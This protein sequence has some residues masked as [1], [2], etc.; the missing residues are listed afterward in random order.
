MLPL[1]L[2]MLGLIYHCIKNRKD[3][4]VVFLMF[5]MTG[6]AIAI[7]LNMPP[8]QPRERD[9]AFVGSFYFFSVWIGLGVYALYDWLST[10]FEKKE[11]NGYLIAG[12]LCVLLGFLF[13]GAAFILT[14]IGVVLLIVSVVRL[15]K[16]VAMPLA[17][18][19]SMRL[20][21]S[22]SRFGAKYANSFRFC[23]F[24]RRLGLDARKF[25]TNV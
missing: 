24:F 4:F 17:F 10:K 9:Y 3:A 22:E 8:R 11:R 5:F 18:V 20:S 7:Y 23:G 15:P 14:L 16:A 1:L 19:L 21:T 25:L 13:N 2:G 12:A 6:L